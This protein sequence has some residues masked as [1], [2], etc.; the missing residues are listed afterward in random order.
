MKALPFSA[1]L[2]ISVQVF[3]QNFLMAVDTTFSITGRGT[4]AT[5]IIERGIVNEGDAV[6][7]VGMGAENL[8]ST[9]TGVEM[10][11][12][13]VDK[14]GAGD[15]V[16]LL[17]RGIERYE[18]KRGMVICK[19]GSVTAHARFKARVYILKKEEGGNHTLFINRYRPK[20]HF[21]TV[22]ITGEIKLPPGAKTIM[23]G[24]HVS[25]EV[26]LINKIAMERDLHFVIRE[27]GRT[28]GSGQ[29]TETLDR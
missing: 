5:G 17:L 25:L 16:G 9:I 7:I 26:E 28:V 18:I 15:T 27:G 20:F 24:E 23:P 6:E 19:P 14:G 11:R 4:V 1:L 2:F 21:R 8:K 13:L 3:S 29:V 10:F 12:K 22:D